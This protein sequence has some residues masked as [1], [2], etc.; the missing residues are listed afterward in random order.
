MQ[1]RR[2]L[3]EYLGEL[4]EAPSLSIGVDHGAHHRASWRA[5]SGTRR[6]GSAGPPSRWHGVEDRPFGGRRRRRHGAHIPQEGDRAQPAVGGWGRRTRVSGKRISFA[7]RA[8]ALRRRRRRHGGVGGEVVGARTVAVAARRLGSADERDGRA[9]GGVEVEAA[10][11]DG[12][13]TAARAKPSCQV[14]ASGD[15][16]DFDAVPRRIKCGANVP[17]RQTR[18]ASGSAAPSR[19]RS[20]TPSARRLA[21]PEQGGRRRARQLARG[22]GARVGRPRAQA[23]SGSS[24]LARSFTLDKS[25]DAPVVVVWCGGGVDAAEIAKWPGR[26]VES[27]IGG[28]TFQKMVEVWLAKMARGSGGGAK[29][30]RRR[31]RRQGQGRPPAGEGRLSTAIGRLMRCRRTRTGWRKLDFGAVLKALLERHYEVTQGEA[32]EGDEGDPL[33]PSIQNARSRRPPRARPACRRRRWTISSGWSSCRRACRARLPPARDR[34]AACTRRWPTSGGGR[35]SV[36][37]G[38]CSA[39]TTSPPCG[40]VGAA[41]EAERA[42][43]ATIDRPSA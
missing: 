43:T 8:R 37:R 2:R 32:D 3:C 21:A 19:A 12:R 16:T 36:Q 41:V 7:A 35:R 6:R 17:A 11:V 1:L 26:E 20:A 14:S 13:R 31:R 24:F 25:K 39:A 38:G 18:A 22:V 4:D 9:A 15:A 33:R 28:A 5:Y 30:T 10:V 42:V 27:E 23:R 40:C 29:G 34:G